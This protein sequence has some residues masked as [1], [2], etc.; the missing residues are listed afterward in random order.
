M[1]MH[2]SSHSWPKD[3]IEALFNLTKTCDFFAWVLRRIDSGMLPVFVAFIV[4]LFGNWT[5]GPSQVSL[6]L[7][8][9]NISSVHQ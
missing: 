3:I 6:N 1:S 9:T 5:V 4:A 7:V 8:I 2:S